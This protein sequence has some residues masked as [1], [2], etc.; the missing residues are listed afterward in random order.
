VK[1]LRDKE[2]VLKNDLEKLRQSP[3]PPSSPDDKRKILE[4]IRHLLD[5]MEMEHGPPRVVA[6]MS[7]ATVPAKPQSDPRWLLTLGALIVALAAGVASAF[8]GRIRRAR[9]PG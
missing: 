5:K 8:A 2:Q 6:V 4:A 7:R 9:R 3:P 1:L